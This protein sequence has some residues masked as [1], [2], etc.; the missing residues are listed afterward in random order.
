MSLSET[1]R[2]RALDNAFLDLRQHVPA[3]LFP[4][5]AQGLRVL[6][7]MRQAPEHVHRFLHH[8]PSGVTFAS[9]DEMIAALGRIYH[10]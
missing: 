10:R 9:Q 5:D 6:M 3:G 2:S 7:A 1:E 8:L 4:T